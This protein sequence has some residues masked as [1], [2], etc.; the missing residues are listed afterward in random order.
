MQRRSISS[1]WRDY[2]V[3]LEAVTSGMKPLHN[4]HYGKG[5]IDL[6]GKRPI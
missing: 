5:A 4:L 3:F 6:S 2:N 1:V